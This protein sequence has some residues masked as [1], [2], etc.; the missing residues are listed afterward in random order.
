MLPTHYD[1]RH[2]NRG[3]KE[4]CEEKSS[5]FHDMALALLLNHGDTDVLAALLAALSP[6]DACAMSQ[7]C[8][9]W[10]LLAEFGLKSACVTYGWK[11]PRRSRLLQRHPLGLPWRALF[12]SRACRACLGAAGDFA[13]RR[14]AANAPQFF[15]CGRCAKH[16][17]VV[18]RMQ[19]ARFTLDVT[20]LS[21][22][23]LYTKRESKFCSDV[24]RL[25]KASLDNASGARAEVL[26]H[27]RT[28]AGGGL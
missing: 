1:G 21:G 20:G 3:V 12:L 26:R 13:V 16:P 9:S 10:A 18:D 14:S 28:G 17:A 6:R 7:V 22:K 11:Q 23:P 25:S 5:V 24:S 19:D 2:D 15:L 8:H 27:A 4:L